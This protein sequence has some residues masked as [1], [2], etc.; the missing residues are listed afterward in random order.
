MNN[1]FPCE[2]TLWQPNVGDHE[3]RWIDNHL[4]LYLYIKFA[5]G[6]RIPAATE[7]FKERTYMK[8]TCRA[9]KA[10]KRLQRSKLWGINDWLW[11]G[12]REM[13][14]ERARKS[15]VPW[16]AKSQRQGK[17]RDFKSH[18]CQRQVNE[19]VI[20]EKVIEQSISTILNV[21]TWCLFNLVEREAVEK[22]RVHWE[23][24]G[25]SDSD[26]LYADDIIGR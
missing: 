14:Q 12:L 22:I 4:G 6:I 18:R 20:N 3:N 17:T 24:E 26:L 8:Q 19:G 16:Y 11:L 10:R 21:S 25:T 2:E 13:K 9:E 7:I 1:Y 23:K 15:I 5:G